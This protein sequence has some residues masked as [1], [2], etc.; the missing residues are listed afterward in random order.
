MSPPMA[1]VFLG[2]DLNIRVCERLLLIQKELAPIIKDQDA[3]VRWV[4][5]EHLHL[6]LRMVGDIERVL[7]KPL[8]AAIE[9]AT[10]QHPPFKITTSTVQAY[11][12][13]DIPRILVA[14]IT[15]GLEPLETLR[16]SIDIEL[17]SLGLQPDSRP[18]YASVVLGRIK[19]PQT[20]ASLSGVLKALTDL[21]LGSSSVRDVSLMQSHLTPKGSQLQVFARAHLR[22]A[23]VTP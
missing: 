19:T 4:L 16:Q 23:R 13:G 6:T 20:R 12:S 18:F 15:K 22:G 14:Q 3:K 9:K 8:H 1:R 10:L 21:P 17:E 11:P 7:F 5:P 2:I